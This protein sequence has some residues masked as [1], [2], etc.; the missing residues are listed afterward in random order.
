MADPLGMRPLN[1][2]RLV[3][4]EGRKKALK[5]VEAPL[6]EQI[7]AKL[8]KTLVD[9]G[10]PSKLEE[11][12]R[13]GNADRADWLTRQKEYLAE[14]DEFVKPIY[15][16]STT[17]GSSLH[18][19][20]TLTIARTYHARMQSALIGTNPPFTAKALK[21]A[22]ADRAMLVQELMGYTLNNWVNDYTGIGQFVDDWLWSWITTGLGLAKV[23]WKTEYTR[24]MDVETQ[25][26]PSA[27]GDLAP[28]VEPPLV[29]VEVEV[30]RTVK[31]C[32]APSIMA[33]DNEDVLIVGGGGDPQKAD[34][35]LEQ[36]YY[37]AD[38]LW[39]LVDRR[40]F[41]KEA[42]ERILEGGPD[43]K[44]GEQVNQ[45]KTLKAENGGESQ[46]DKSFE[47]AKYQILECYLKYDVDGSGIA[48]DV[49]AWIHPRSKEMLA[50]TYLRRRM[51]TGYR[52]YY[53]IDF[54][55]RKG[56]TYPAGMVELLYSLSKEIDA[57]HNIILDVGVLT[58]QPFGFYRPT[59]SLAG[60]NLPIEP[61]SLIPL[62][63]P[64]GDVYFPNLGNRVSFGYQEMGFL[65]GIIE[66]FMSVSDITFGS[67]GSQGASRTATGTRTLVQETNANLDVV[68]RRMHVG[69]SGILKHLFALLQIKI[70]PGFMFRLLGDDGN[71][72][73]ATITPDD[74]KGSYDFILEPN[75]ANSNKQIQLDIATQIYQATANPLDMQ[76]GLIT[77]VERYEAIKN[78]YQALGVKN[79][80]RYVRKP[81]GGPQFTPKDYVEAALAGVRLPLTPNIDLGG[82]VEFGQSVLENDNYVGQFSEQQMIS[83]VNLVQ[84]AGEMLQAMQAQQAQSAN[85]MQQQANAQQAGGVLD[86]MAMPQNQGAPAPVEGQP[87]A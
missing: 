42:V 82:I 59:G 38:M 9:R 41:N 56:S 72:V 48:S 68:I 1:N 10:V 36:A 46:L 33:L 58:S 12:W 29:P 40:I 25:M 81:A 22:N 53:R 24:Y 8:R 85:Q 86:Q 80:S 17:W 52:P 57:M 18:L 16:A 49:I 70:E 30:E 13:L 83:L 62:D 71:D 50:A 23:S 7:V 43:M 2:D 21:G 32:D 47:A 55:R 87:P 34:Y 19:P 37:T 76:M 79:Y 54:Y 63:N 4:Q 15:K 14:V 35:V 51:P 75:S 44:G 84:E 28:D 69:W 67:T 45:I 65:N 6:R 64:Q 3:V 66:R 26:Q 61:G 5:G 73:W 27:A 39:Q 77:P 78:Y 74:I 20:T 60:E 31:A 11:V